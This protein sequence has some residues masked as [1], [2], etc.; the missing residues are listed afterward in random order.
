MLLLDPRTGRQF[1][2]NSAGAL[3][4]IADGKGKTITCLY[5]SS[6]G[7]LFNVSDNAG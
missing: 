4:S 2:F 3:T 5:S 6:S 7:L 1:T